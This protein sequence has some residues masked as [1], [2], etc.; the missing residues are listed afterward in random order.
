VFKICSKAAEVVSY[1]NERIEEMDRQ[2]YQVRVRADK[3]TDNVMD[4]L[5]Q[6]GCQVIR[7]KGNSRAASVASTPREVVGKASTHSRCSSKNSAI[8]KAE[9]KL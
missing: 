6:I 8:D 5:K 3:P 4:D 9:Y 7:Q 1:K 2:V